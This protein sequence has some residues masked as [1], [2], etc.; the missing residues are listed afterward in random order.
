M[1][2][3][4][5]FN[6]NHLVII[7][8]AEGDTNFDIAGQESCLQIKGALMQ[9]VK[10]SLYSCLMLK[11]W[12]LFHPHPSFRRSFASLWAAGRK[13]YNEAA[14]TSLEFAPL[15]QEVIASVPP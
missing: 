2:A 5:A 13:K 11:C 14:G 10:R 9:S 3:H 12:H 4:M 6:R 1:V 7:F 15:V 8:Q